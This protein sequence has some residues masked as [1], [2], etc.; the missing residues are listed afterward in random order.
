M[1]DQ[2]PPTLKTKTVGG[3]DFPDER[4]IGVAYCVQSRSGFFDV[5]E[6][7]KT[8]SKRLTELHLSESVVPT[9]KPR[10][11]GPVAGWELGERVNVEVSSALYDAGLR[12]RFDE[13]EKEVVW[14]LG[15][16]VQ[17]LDNAL[18]PYQMYFTK[19]AAPQQIRD[20]LTS[21]L[22]GKSRGDEKTF[23]LAMFLRQEPGIIRQ[24]YA[25]EARGQRVAILD[26]Y[27][28]LVWLVGAIYD[29]ILKQDPSLLKRLQFYAD[30]HALAIPRDDAQHLASTAGDPSSLE[31]V[32][33]DL[34]LA[35]LTPRTDHHAPLFLEQKPLS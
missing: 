4:P 6:L 13:E 14:F 2:P 7:Y 25:Q 9:E 30:H 10:T 20:D 32:L 15:A 22:I 18:L 3:L 8:F 28:S 26:A 21:G 11:W 16:D 17:S 31:G 27:R 12:L 29:P 5:Q 33:S 35:Q 34:A 24:A 23:D 19:R 1:G